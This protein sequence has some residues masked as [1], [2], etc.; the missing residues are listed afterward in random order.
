MFEDAVAVLT[1][2]AVS[3]SSPL[4][5]IAI[6]AGAGAEAG[7]PSTDRWAARSV[8]LVK[9]IHG[10]LSTRMPSQCLQTR[11]DSPSA[12]RRASSADGGFP[13]TFEAS[14]AIHPDA[15][16]PHKPGSRVP[17]KVKVLQKVHCAAE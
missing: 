4:E 17:G 9:T 3:G 14:Y 12:R 1:F 13:V 11:Y 5:G 16:M 15:A 8:L 10:V 7:K 6:G 2:Q